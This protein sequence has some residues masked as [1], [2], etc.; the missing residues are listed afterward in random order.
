MTLTVTE[1]LPYVIGAGALLYTL[2]PLLSEREEAPPDDDDEA[3][4]ARLV[5]RRDVIYSN[6][7]DL[8]FETAMGKLSEEDSQEL[9]D[10]MLRDAAL[11]LEE[12]DVVEVD[13]DLDR[14]I[15]E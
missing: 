7:R 5:A 4:A 2:R 11:V 9:R 13:P 8:E 10:E 1:F 6:I 15:E 3:P 12:L 14:W